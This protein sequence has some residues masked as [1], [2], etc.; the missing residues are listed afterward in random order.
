M[1]NVKYFYHLLNYAPLCEVMR[2]YAI[3][4]GILNALKNAGYFA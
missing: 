3:F 2:S 4:T 1:A